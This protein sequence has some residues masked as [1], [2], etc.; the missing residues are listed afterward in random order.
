M[1]RLSFDTRQMKPHMIHQI[2]VTVLSVVGVAI[3]AI[4]FYGF[5]DSMTASN[6]AGVNSF[7]DKFLIWGALTIVSS[8]IICLIGAFSSTPVLQS[9]STGLFGFIFVFELV[10]MIGVHACR[11]R[12][13]GGFAYLFDEKQC[14]YTNHRC[15]AKAIAF[16]R[17]LM[18]CGW[19]DL[20]EAVVTNSTEV[21]DWV[22]VC[23]TVTNEKWKRLSSNLTLKMV[24]AAA[25]AVY[26]VVGQL[27]RL[28]GG[29]GR[30]RSEYGALDVVQ[31]TPL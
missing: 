10:V 13:V 21:C 27:Y 9:I 30:K 26:C 18:C 12:L 14:P 5:Y 24:F 25:A 4:A 1:S 22:D 19:N 23:H 16:E 3:T 8:L 7:V 2:L 15:T 11:E 31:S 29:P 17:G 6:M 28:L 20:K